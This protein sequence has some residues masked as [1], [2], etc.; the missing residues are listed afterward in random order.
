M[1]SDEKNKTK[2]VKVPA[3][4]RVS[5]LINEEGKKRHTSF[6]KLFD[7]YGG[8]F[9]LDNIIF[10]RIVEASPEDFRAFVKEVVP[11]INLVYECVKSNH[12]TLISVI[13]VNNKVN[14][15]FENEVKKMTNFN[16]FELWEW[17]RQNHS[18][19]KISK[20]HNEIKNE[21]DACFFKIK[22][23]FSRIQQ[24]Y[25][26]DSIQELIYL[27]IKFEYLAEAYSRD[28]DRDS[29]TIHYMIQGINHEIFW[30]TDVQDRIDKEIISRK[31]IIR[32]A[33]VI[34]SEGYATWV[35]LKSME[36]IFKVYQCQNFFSYLKEREKYYN[37]LDISHPNRKGLEIY[38]NIE[39]T[40]GLVCT[41]LSKV[42][43]YDISIADKTTI[44]SRMY[45]S[46]ELNQFFEKPINN[47]NFRIAV[48]GSLT[49]EYEGDNIEKFIKYTKAKIID[50]CKKCMKCDLWG[51]L[52][53]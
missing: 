4:L 44:D 34:E 29:L 27:L 40:F 46:K 32:T 19:H 5:I 8:S 22:Q 49:K 33:T 25:K 10:K 20:A 43:S 18:S 36:A 28:V 41:H 11:H 26:D 53:K 23:L 9:R 35:E 48:I 17:Y 24:L 50:E 30:N 47:P 7:S 3:S 13:E 37:N 2:V 31:N 1:K 15:C 39:R 6:E 12:R 45:T 52:I 16:R 42:I 14:E 51:N 21:I 38:R